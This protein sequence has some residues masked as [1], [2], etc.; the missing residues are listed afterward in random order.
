[1]LRSAAPWPLEDASTLRSKRQR[2]TSSA[3][4]TTYTP[5]PST[6][7]L[8]TNSVPWIRG[9]AHVGEEVR[10]AEARRYA[11]FG[12]RRPGAAAVVVWVP[13]VACSRSGGGCSALAPGRGASEQ[14]ARA[15]AA[16]QLG[17]PRAWHRQ[18]DVDGPTQCGAGECVAACKAAILDGRRRPHDADARARFG[19]AV[20]DAEPCRVA[21]GGAPTARAGRP[22][23]LYGQP[24]SV[25]AAPSGALAARGRTRYNGG[26]GLAALEGE[27]PGAAGAVDQ[28]QV[29]P[30]QRLQAQHLATEVQGS[31]AGPGVDAC[32]Q[33][34]RQQ[35]SA[36][37]L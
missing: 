25:G 26:P 15:H 7:W 34:T 14:A 10:V 1:M 19:A 13:L 4:S 18:P 9:P 17:T 36:A 16:G 12:E 31:V 6:A 8:Y 27:R 37:R 29:A 22:L 32:R 24:P 3:A 5:P 33:G 21:G 28:G 2:W 11:S 20:G 23:T 35:R 30:G